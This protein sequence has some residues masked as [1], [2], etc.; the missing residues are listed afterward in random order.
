VG[1]MIPGQD[2]ECFYSNHYSWSRLDAAKNGDIYPI[3]KNHPEDQLGPQMQAIQAIL[4]GGDDA[5][6]E[7]E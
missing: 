3:S 7:I 1:R 2:P 5:K 4:K 6:Q